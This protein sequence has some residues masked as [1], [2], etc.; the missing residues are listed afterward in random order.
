MADNE[1]WSTLPYQPIDCGFHDELLAWAT[2]QRQVH[3]VY[4]DDHGE[5]TRVSDVITDVYTRAG[6][7]W[8][9]LQ[10]GTTIRLDGIIQVNE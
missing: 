1:G 10:N 2:L 3:I 5:E 8:M 6:A 7:E 4:Q 9:Q